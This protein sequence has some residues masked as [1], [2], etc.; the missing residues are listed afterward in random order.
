[1]NCFTGSSRSLFWLPSILCF[2]ALIFAADLG[3]QVGVRN[4]FSLNLVQSWLDE[5]PD[6]TM[7]LKWIPELDMQ[8]SFSE[9]TGLSLS[10]S[11]QSY[12]FPLQD[13]AELETKLYRGWLKLDKSAWSLSL[14]LQRINF[15]TAEL[16]RPEQWFDRLSPLDES[17]E[18]EGV[19][20]ALGSIPLGSTG[21]M[22]LWA[23]RSENEVRGNEIIPS[24]PDRIEPGGRLEIPL[25]PVFTGLSYHKREISLPQQPEA[26]EHRLGLDL[27]W[28][29][30]FG[31]WLESSGSVFIAPE[32][33]LYPEFQT[34]LSLGTDYTLSL[35]NGLYLRQETGVWH[36]TNSKLSTLHQD[37]VSTAL[38]ATY[39]LSL[40]DNLQLLNLYNWGSQD[41]LS[42]LQLSRTYDYWS[43][44]ISVSQSY[45]KDV[46]PELRLRVAYNI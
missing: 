41:A 16:I 45:K 10:L 39:P 33:S 44:Y 3:A 30:V 34:A 23:I 12:L 8:H 22:M 37:F 21:Q 1:M 40:L 18:T 27:R 19:V 17:E 24:V 9:G 5:E 28:D 14:G 11:G 25:G 43:F 35:G 4:L 15:G 31:A 36:S 29:G 26:E 46:Y 38:L 20:A 42:T 2:T 32:S 6:Q 13:K 7:S